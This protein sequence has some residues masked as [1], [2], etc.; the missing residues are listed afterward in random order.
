MAQKGGGEQGGSE[1]VDQAMAAQAAAFFPGGLH[2]REALEEE[3]GE[4][5]GH[6]V[7]D[8]AAQEG[9]T[10]EGTDVDQAGRVVGGDGGLRDGDFAGAT[11]VE[12]AS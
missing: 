9:E 4:D 6:Q 11:T 3:H 2:Q 12:V 5:A 8:D 7:E 1:G 10:D